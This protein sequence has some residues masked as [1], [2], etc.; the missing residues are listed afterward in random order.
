VAAGIAISLFF[1]VRYI[2]ERPQPQTAPP[3]IDPASYRP[4]PA[5]RQGDNIKYLATGSATGTYI[6]LGDA[7][8]RFAHHSD[9]LHIQACTSDGSDQNL[10]LLANHAVAFALVQLDTLHYR[11]SD[12][13]EYTCNDEAGS[14]KGTSVVGGRLGRNEISI[15]TYLYSEKVHLFVRPHLYLSSPADLNRIPDKEHRIWLGPCGGG[16]Y[17]TAVKILEAAGISDHEIKEF[18]KDRGKDLRADWDRAA[19][20]LLAGQ[21]D[22]CGLT[23][24][25]RTKSVPHNKPGDPVDRL[26]VNDAQIMGLPQ[27]IIDRLTE[28]NLYVE[29]TISLGTYEHMRRGVP[30]VGIPTVL[31]TNLGEDADVRELIKGLNDNR[32]AIE[33]QINVRLDELNTIPQ[34]AVVDTGGTTPNIGGIPIHPGAVDHFR[35]RG[36]GLLWPSLFILGVVLAAWRDPRWFRRKIAS[37]SYIILLLSALGALWFILSVAMMRVEGTLNP[38][39][40]GRKALWNTL[41]TIVGQRRDPLMTRQGEVLR[42]LGLFLFP[43]IMGWLFSDVIKDLLRRAS[44]RLALVIETGRARDMHRPLIA[45]ARLPLRFIDWM[46][47]RP[48]RNGAVIFLNWNDRAEHMISELRHSA[49]F[50]DRRVIV[51]QAEGSQLHPSADLR[52]TIVDGDPT[53]RPTMERAEVGAAASVT[54]LSSWPPADPEDRRRKLDPDAADTKTVLA[55]L[56]IRSLCEELRRSR[57]LPITAEIQLARTQEAARSAARGGKL[58]INCL[59]V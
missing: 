5:Q 23:A 48:D 34:N 11:V 37:I 42:W 46:L 36:L 39:F 15:V 41:P 24:Y 38:D 19:S 49:E 31:V 52:V 22:N 40:V 30:T 44:A 6:R 32:D 17:G 26:L 18:G 13:L 25:F 2:A 35:R 50:A 3:D 20:C 7:I 57:V 4:C 51:V 55:I 53:A 21:E 14:E 12:D 45:L 54:I 8:A 16:G 27:S 58:D 43:V 33:T 28:D 56:T 1:L 59:P 29:T 9:T 47:R 10:R